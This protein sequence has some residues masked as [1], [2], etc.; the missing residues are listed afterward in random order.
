MSIKKLFAI[1]F[2]NFFFLILT[3]F[4]VNAKINN[5]EFSNEGISV[6][7]TSLM[8]WKGTGRIL[9]NDDNTAFVVWY[10]NVNGFIYANKSNLLQDQPCYHHPNQK[11]INQKTTIYYHENQIYLH[12]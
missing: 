4:N 6:S 5:F 3:P 11:V 9:A 10:N 2:A 7:D 1:L 8:E 12:I